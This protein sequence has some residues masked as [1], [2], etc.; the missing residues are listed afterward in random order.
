MDLLRFATAGSVDDGK[1]TLIGRLLYDSKQVFD[2]VMEGLKRSTASTNFEDE[3]NLALLTDVPEAVDSPGAR[4]RPPPQGRNQTAPAMDVMGFDG[5]VEDFRRAN[6]HWDFASDALEALPAKPQRDPMVGR[7]FGAV[8]AYFAWRLGRD[9]AETFTDP[10]A[11]FKYGSTGGDRN[12]GIPYAMW[13]A[14]PTLFRDLLP[15]GREDE[16]WA[17]FGFLYEDPAELPPE[18][19]H[20]RPVGTSLRNSMGIDRIFLNCAGCHAGSVR[21]GPGGAQLVIVF[22]VGGAAQKKIQAEKKAQPQK[23]GDAK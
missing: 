17:A 6:P 7:W 23:G 18:L 2:D 12:F 20:P 21:T 3:V 13:Q 8:A 16:G 19:R 10:V 22:G 4:R 11:Q 15:E 9:T 1:S 14:M 5:R